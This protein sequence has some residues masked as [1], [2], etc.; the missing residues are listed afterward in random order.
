[1]LILQCIEDHSIRA[2]SGVGT[3]RIVKDDTTLSMS[4][5]YTED[6]IEEFALMLDILNVEHRETLIQTLK[7]RLTM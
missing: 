2:S 7:D 6:V 1:M 5:A 3:V 4:I